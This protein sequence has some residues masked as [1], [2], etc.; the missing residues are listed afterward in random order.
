MPELCILNIYESEHAQFKVM[1]KSLEKEMVNPCPGMF[2][3]KSWSTQSVVKM[4]RWQSG[5]ILGMLS[6][7]N[8]PS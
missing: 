8:K 6:S 1:I 4:E 7:H 5:I 2:I 3:P